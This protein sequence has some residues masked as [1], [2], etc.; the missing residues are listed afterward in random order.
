[1]FIY[2][3]RAHS[4]LCNR[5]KRKKQT[6]LDIKN[7]ETVSFYKKLFFRNLNSF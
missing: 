4:E 7:G 5:K 6:F 3:L 2:F 1:M